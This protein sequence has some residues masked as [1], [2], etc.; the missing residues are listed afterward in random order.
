MIQETQLMDGSV[1]LDGSSPGTSLVV[2]E[3]YGFSPE[4]VMLSEPNGA[5]AEAVRTLRTHLMA[6]HVDSGHR[7]LA[8]C[9]AS[10]GVGATFTAVNLAVA[11]AQIGTKVL[12]IDGDLRNAGVDQFIRPAKPVPGF[13]AC[14][15]DTQSDYSP[16]IQRD[17]IPNLSVMF[18]G[19]VTGS[20]QEL[21]ASERF[22]EVVERC[23]REYD[24]TII[25]T[26]PANTCAD[27]RRICTVAGYGIIVA[28]RNVSFVNDIKVLAAQLEE[29]RAHVV[30][31]V[32]N[33][34]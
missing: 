3:V 30:G 15:A 2:R 12:F 22:A 31:T 28:K 29:D 7:G 9:G 18:A 34:A 8:I 5:R 27:A 32:L 6:Q 24:V 10:A 14:L 13:A 26:P 1:N 25:D 17:V 21:L 23:L 16:Y 20:A 11:L 33:E 19:E 4:I